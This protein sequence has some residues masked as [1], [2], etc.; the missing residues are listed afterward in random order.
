MATADELLARSSPEVR[1]VAQRL[2][3]VVLDVLPG[4]IQETVDLADNLLAYVTG[5]R[6]RDIVIGII[7]HTS[8]VNLQFPDGVDLPDPSGLLEGTG[9]R[10]RHVKNRSVADADRAAVRDLITTQWRFAEGR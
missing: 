10:A 3:A 6:L 7:P 8:H 2:R 4:T 1:A 9:R 5:P